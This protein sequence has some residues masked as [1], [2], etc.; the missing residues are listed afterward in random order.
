MELFVDI[1]VLLRRGELV[2]VL[3][4]ND[5]ISML[6]LAGKNNTRPDALNTHT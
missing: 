4:Y 3:Y 2:Y 6:L 5:D 1:S